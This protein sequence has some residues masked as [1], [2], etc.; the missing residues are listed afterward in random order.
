MT[1]RNLITWKD[2]DQNLCW[3]AAFILDKAMHTLRARK[4]MRG[5][6][7]VGR[8]GNVDPGFAED[9]GKRTVFSDEG[10]SFKGSYEDGG[11][12]VADQLTTSEFESLVA[13]L[14]AIMEE[15]NI[16]LNH[17]TH[18]ELMPAHS[19]LNFESWDNPA[20]FVGY[21]PQCWWS[22]QNLVRQRLT[23][24]RQELK[25][26]LY[27]K[28]NSRTLNRQSSRNKIKRKAGSKYNR[29]QERQ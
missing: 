29:Q 6:Y 2:A 14:R 26:N 25:S 16:G 9:N 21:S 10:I 12:I 18:D 20:A 8:S 27:G 24:A 19:H 1:K 17:W 4:D 11:Y 3:I 28:S 13:P 23:Q 22:F 15:W 5:P 7:P